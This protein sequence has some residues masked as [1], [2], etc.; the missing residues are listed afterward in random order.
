MTWL[1]T[2]FKREKRNR[3]SFFLW[4]E[5]IEKR[6]VL[7]ERKVDTF[8]R[9]CFCHWHLHRLVSIFFKRRAWIYA[10]PWKIK[11]M[12]TASGQWKSVQLFRKIE[13]ILET[14]HVLCAFAG[15]RSHGTNKLESFTTHVFWILFPL[16]VLPRNFQIYSVYFFTLELSVW[17]Q[18][19]ME[20]WYA[21]SQR[22]EKLKYAPEQL[23]LVLNRFTGSCCG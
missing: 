14:L 16:L 5:E 12:Y 8:L 15:K 10:F 7:K 9:L 3:N 1:V 19:W 18:K 20:V 11:R 22:K 4:T 2:F 17:S 6:D 23:V 13:R 21:H